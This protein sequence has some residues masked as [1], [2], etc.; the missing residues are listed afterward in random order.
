MTTSVDIH[1]TTELQSAELEKWVQSAL[2]VLDGPEVRILHDSVVQL[3]KCETGRN[4]MLHS[5]K[6]AGFPNVEWHGPAMGLRD[7]VNHAWSLATGTAPVQSQDSDERF[8]NSQIDMDPELYNDLD[9]N[10]TSTAELRARDKYG[11]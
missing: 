11:Y 1:F 2:W 4:E 7:K 8:R 10:Q 3:I 9:W 6:F 5:V